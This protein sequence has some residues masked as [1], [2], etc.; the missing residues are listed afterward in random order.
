MADEALSIAK[1]IHSDAQVILGPQTKAKI[2]DQHELTRATQAV[3]QQKA[4]LYVEAMS[5]HQIA[6]QTAL[7]TLF[8]LLFVKRICRSGVILTRLMNAER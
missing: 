3:L 7:E 8:K 4:A 5:R 1:Q 6:T 2:A